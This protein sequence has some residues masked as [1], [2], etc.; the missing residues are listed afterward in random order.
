VEGTIQLLSIRGT[1]FLIV[2]SK[3][4]QF[5]RKEELCKLLLEVDMRAGFKPTR[6]ISS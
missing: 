6:A 4:G 3:S 2:D 5:L 1:D